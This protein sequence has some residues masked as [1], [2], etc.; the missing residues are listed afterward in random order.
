MPDFTGATG[1]Q[2]PTADSAAIGALNGQTQAFTFTFSDPNGATDVMNTYIVMNTSPTPA[3]G[4]SIRYTEYNGG[5]P[6]ALYLMR[7]DGVNWDQAVLPS[8]AVLQNSRCIVNAADLIITEAVTTF[9]E[10]LTIT[11]K[12][13]FS[14]TQTIYMAVQDYAGAFSNFQP[15]GS[16][17]IA[18]YTISGRVATGTIPPIGVPNVQVQLNT[19]PVQ[20]I[21]TDANGDYA[22]T[23]LGP[24]NFVVT[25]SHSNYTFTPANTPVNITSSSVP[26]VNFT[27]VPNPT[28]W[29]ITGQVTQGGAG[30]SGVSMALTLSNGEPN[31][32]CEREL[33]FYQPGRGRQLQDNADKGGV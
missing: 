22:F 21:S 8:T 15:R 12:P 32:E 19:T 18:G 4:C 11:P 33:F 25:P 14:G 2:P 6:R 23:A 31:N 27:A 7:D 24:G 17:T 16:W 5:Q 30:L 28:Y 3:T 29:N 26:N 9:T 13:G 1:N 10:Q 20:T